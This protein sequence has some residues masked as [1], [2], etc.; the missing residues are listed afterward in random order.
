[1]RIFGSQE[2]DTDRSCTLSTGAIPRVVLPNIPGL[3]GSI[4]SI[5]LEQMPNWI[6]VDGA[7]CL[8]PRPVIHVY[9]LKLGIDFIPII[10][11]RGC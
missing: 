2:L 5:Q 10:R 6:T 9:P 11:R 7:V 1:M 4:R 8:K 3:W